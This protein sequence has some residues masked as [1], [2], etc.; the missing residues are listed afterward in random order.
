V[1][2]VFYSDH[3]TVPLPPEHRFPMA[4]YARLRERLLA[5]NVL[6]PSELAPAE[7]APLEAV[8]AVHDPA[9]VRAFVD[10]TLDRKAIQ[11]IG[12]PWSRELVARCFA[13][14]GGTLQAAHAALEH[15]FGA[16]LAGGTHHAHRDFGA[17]FCVF[18]DIAI[19]AV[20]LL[21]RGALERVLVVDLDVHQGDGTA[22]IFE[23]DERVF[24]FSMHG[25]RN[26]PARK[27]RSDLDVALA[28]ATGDEL[29]LALLRE[30]L[31]AAVE[32][33]RPDFVFYQAGV[34][35]L[36]SDKL[37][38]LALTHAGL[39]ERDEHVFT[40]ARELGLPIVLTLGGGYA[41]PIDDSIA[42]HVDTYRAAR[43]LF[44]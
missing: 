6:Q 16:N 19:A 2:R 30:H 23:G 41:Q 10:G 9:Y 7:P 31:A 38:R 33:S 26:F 20:D 43:E 36:A 18:N 5:E 14:A 28:D 4:K 34:D 35:P 44:G 3:F 24:T 29:Y 8:L 17:G 37:G 39:R 21:A 1:L 42:A 12:F 11:R 22:A 27:Q 32:R 15:G 25:E 13:S 40:T